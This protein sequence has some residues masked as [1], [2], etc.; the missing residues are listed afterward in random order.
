MHGTTVKR[1]KKTVYKMSLAS[2]PRSL[3][4]YQGQISKY[5]KISN[6]WNI[7]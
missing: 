7:T 4:I 3:Q 6:Y 5:V 1:K 2:L